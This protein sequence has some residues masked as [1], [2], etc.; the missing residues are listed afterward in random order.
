MDEYIIRVSTCTDLMPGSGE[1]VPG[2][3]DQ[4]ARFDENGLPY[5]NA[6]TIKGHI[7]EQMEHL[8]DLQPQ[9]YDDVDIDHLLG[10][11]DV[12]GEKDP[13]I[14]HFSDLTL[15][16]ELIASVHQAI[17]D[18]KLYRDEVQNSLS[19]VA[20]TTQI[21]DQGIV[22]DHSLRSMRLIDQGLTF[23]ASVLAMQSLTTAEEKLFTDAVRSLQ[24]I[25]MQKS[26]GRGLIQC[27]L[28]KE[29]RR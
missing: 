27:T 24:H 14:L 8:V 28:A 18:G 10:A 3:I 1:S 22:K 9:R 5:M 7:R 4:E 20:T 12:R 29:E 13:A 17:K 26:K 11:E 15:P 2:V 23:N 21:D 19:T 25:G 6:K 16:A